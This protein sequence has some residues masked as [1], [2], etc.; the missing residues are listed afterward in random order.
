M[1]IGWHDTKHAEIEI[2]KSEQGVSIMLPMAPD[3]RFP[4]PLV[5]LEDVHFRYTPKGDFILRG[6]DLTIHMGDR[7]GV[8][9]LNGCGKS[10]LIK[11]VTEIARPDRGTV[12]RHPRLRLGYYSQHTVEDLQRLG[13]GDLSRTAL[14]TLAADVGDQ[15]TEQ[16]M[17]GLLGSFGLQ[18]R[19]AS[20]VPI[21][22]LS[23]GQ[24]VSLARSTFFQAQDKLT[25]ELSIL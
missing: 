12:T 22:K 13:R 7:V 24:L 17:R 20:E 9:G 23:G 14:N 6:L 5:S 10:T 18:G 11:I 15:M 16:E 21:A 8:V 2:P 4:G 3:L 1:R 25:R 19:T